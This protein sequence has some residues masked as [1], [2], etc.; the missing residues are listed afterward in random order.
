MPTLNTKMSTFPSVP[1][2]EVI[3]YPLLPNP[4]FHQR[5]EY[6]KTAKDEM[7]G[8]ETEVAIFRIISDSRDPI[9]CDR[10]DYYQLSIVNPI[11]PRSDYISY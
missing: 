8:K 7:T 11:A 2:E 10:V 1:L 5:E 4:V 6:I 3:G 9:I